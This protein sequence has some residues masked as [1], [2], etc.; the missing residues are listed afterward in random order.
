MLLVIA[1][2]DLFSLLVPAN[3]IF[4]LVD[5]R[6][7][8]QAALLDAEHGVHVEQLVELPHLEE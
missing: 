6:K 1:L 8:Y 5:S 2:S 3:A 4:L 7:A